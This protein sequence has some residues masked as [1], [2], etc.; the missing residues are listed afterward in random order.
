ML[1]FPK[2]RTSQVLANCL[3]QGLF[4]VKHQW[5]SFLKLFLMKHRV[6]DVG[7][8][9]DGLQHAKSR[10][11]HSTWDFS[12]EPVCWESGWPKPGRL[13]VSTVLTEDY[14][15]L[16]EPG[17]TLTVLGAVAEELLKRVGRIKKPRPIVLRFCESIKPGIEEAFD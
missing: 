13:M 3:V 12:R 1:W 6:K 4:I 14:K 2:Y 5:E 7:I 10:G 15:D 17:L 8:F 11:F 9:C 16:D